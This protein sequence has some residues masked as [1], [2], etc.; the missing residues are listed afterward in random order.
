M[1]L[2]DKLVSLEDLAV[3]HGEC[4]DLKSATG[5]LE[6]TTAG[7]ETRLSTG[8]FINGSG[9]WGSSAA[10]KYAAIPIAAGDRVSIKAGY[11]VSIYACLKADYSGSS[12]VSFADGVS[13][14][15]TLNE[16]AESSF[17]APANSNFLYVLAETSS[18]IPLQH[19]PAVLLINGREY[20]GD[21]RDMLVVDKTITNAVF[22][23]DGLPVV[24]IGDFISGNGSWLSGTTYA[25]MLWPIA[26]GDKIGIE[27]G[28][29]IA[30]I[31]FLNRPRMAGETSPVFAYGETGR[32][33]VTAG[34]R[35]EYTAPAGS[36]WLYIAHHAGSSV[37]IPT[38]LAVNGV[39]IIGGVAKKASCV[40]QYA[41]GSFESGAA[42]EKLVVAIPNKDHYVGFTMLHYIVEDTNC[43][44]WRV[45]SF[46]RLNSDLTVKTALS[47]KGELECAVSLDGRTDFSGGSTHGDEVET[48]VEFFLDGKRITS[49]LSGYTTA[50]PFRELR[51]VRQSNLYDPDDHETVIAEHGCEYVYT[52]DG[53][54]I[55]QSLKWKG[56]YTL[57]NCF[58]AMFTPKKDVTDHYYSD[59]DFTPAALSSSDYSI[60]KDGAKKA[61]IYGES[62]G[63][64][65]EFFI[66][67]YPTGL[68]GGDRLLLT[69]NGGNSYN[70]MYYFIAN[71]GTTAENDLWQTVTG[72][73]IRA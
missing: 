23:P 27:A 21:L 17:V 48:G 35:G 29:D 13:G 52:L 38:E 25:Y 57:D 56:A 2:K 18:S 58:M 32:R 24:R 68:T 33:S 55:N 69:D 40:M 53:L 49:A 19:W 41:S 37:Y 73:R 1:A 47:T 26:A 36:K 22:G 30:L 34:A 39:S 67:R 50:T 20:G 46:D 3:V 54:K 5:K 14:R 10:A 60:T 16:G 6:A 71:G 7:W 62:S 15:T 45:F 12:S 61:V 66:E 72:Y 11:G 42:T 4:T 51:I 63:F 43:N 59:I 64:E 28:S 70:K 9:N 31:A 65:A 8:R 44:V